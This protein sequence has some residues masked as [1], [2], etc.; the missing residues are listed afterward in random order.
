MCFSVL[1]QWS[2]LGAKAQQLPLLRWPSAQGPGRR[3]DRGSVVTGT[4]SP[5]TCLGNHRAV[6]MAIIENNHFLLTFETINLIKCHLTKFCATEA[7]MNDS[8]IG[9][10]S[11]F[12]NSPG[13]ESS[14]QLH[15]L[16]LSH[17]LSNSG[18][19]RHFGVKEKESPIS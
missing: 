10:E 3:T 12:Q 16:L 2:F 4:L 17:S 13:C 1:F 19:T 14:P 15:A 8:H 18:L 9:T 6:R 7:T 11:D 5:D